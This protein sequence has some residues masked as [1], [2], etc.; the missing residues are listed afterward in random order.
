ML[1]DYECLMLNALLAHFS[2]SIKKFNRVFDIKVDRIKLHIIICINFP[3]FAPNNVDRYFF[4]KI[5]I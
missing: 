4:D 1:L 2:E 3:E 5:T